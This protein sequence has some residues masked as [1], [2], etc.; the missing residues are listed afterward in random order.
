M[1]PIEPPMQPDSAPQTQDRRNGRQ[2]RLYCDGPRR[3]LECAR[4]PKC[5]ALLIAPLSCYLQ[6]ACAGAQSA[7]GALANPSRTRPR[8]ALNL[9][10]TP[11]TQGRRMLDIAGPKECLKQPTGKIDHPTMIAE[12]S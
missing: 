9:G 7:G 3:S 6:S 5:T 4:A 11:V 2:Q 8:L 1:L 12:E 10:S